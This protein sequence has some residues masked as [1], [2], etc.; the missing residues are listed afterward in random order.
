M[1]KDAQ[2]QESAPHPDDKGPQSKFRLHE[3]P[4]LAGDMLVLCDCF[5]CVDD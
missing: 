4:P 1:T 5:G 3:P 2:V